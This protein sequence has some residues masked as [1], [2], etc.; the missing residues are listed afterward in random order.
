MANVLYCLSCTVYMYV[1]LTTY[2][3]MYY[4]KRITSLKWNV[5]SMSAY[6]TPTSNIIHM[7]PCTV[8]ARATSN[9]TS[10][11]K[12]RQLESRQDPICSMELSYT[13]VNMSSSFQNSWNVKHALKYFIQSENNDCNQYY[14]HLEDCS[15][16]YG[17]KELSLLSF[18]NICKFWFK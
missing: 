12:I 9:V 7:Y 15:V 10:E 11:S 13:H 1:V 4:L 5:V 8:V 3:H 2:V 17:S 16:V 18:I 6:H 14:G